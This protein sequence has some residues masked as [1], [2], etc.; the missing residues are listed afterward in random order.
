MDWPSQRLKNDAAAIAS[1]MIE[2]AQYSASLYQM[3]G[4][5]CEVFWYDNSTD[6]EEPATWVHET[7]VPCDYV[8]TAQEYQTRSFFVLTLE[9]HPD[10]GKTRE[11]VWSAKKHYAYSFN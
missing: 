9:Y 1:V 8:F 6:I 11:K 10:F 4:V 5:M 7:E 2:R 3:Y